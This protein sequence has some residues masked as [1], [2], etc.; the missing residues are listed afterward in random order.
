MELEIGGYK[1]LDLRKGLE[2]YSGDNV[3]RLNSGR[4]GIYYAIKKYNCSKALIP[5]YECST[6][7]EFLAKK[8]VRIEYYHIDKYFNP[9]IDKAIDSDTALIVVNYFG[10]FSK[11]K[12][13][14]LSYISP[15]IIVDNSQGFFSTPI[16]NVYNVYS[17]RKFFGVPDG[18]YVIGNNA[19][20]GAEEYDQDISSGTSSFLLRRIETGANNNYAYYLENERRIDQSDIKR[21]S[22]LTS[23]LLDS[24]DYKEYLT[25]RRQNFKTSKELFSSLNQMD[26]SLVENVEE[27]AAPIAY[28]LLVRN[29]KLR[30]FLKEKHIYVGQWWRYLVDE[31]DVSS[32]ESYYSRYLFPIPIDHRYGENEL[33]Y[34]YEIIRE[35]L[36][37]VL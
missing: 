35:S 18:A 1:E 12:I 5:F 14:S 4:A 20:K 29:D 37:S 21:M 32:I 16:E 26:C 19:C 36:K 23:S 6:V 2:Y 22:K 33:L 8:C 31:M 24:I 10:L 9:I 25:K 34:I 13:E 17:P 11:E 15:N 7:R 27:D 3:C 30:S 28:P